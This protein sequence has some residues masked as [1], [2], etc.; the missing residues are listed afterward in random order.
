MKKVLAIGDAEAIKG[1]WAILNRSEE[2][3]DMPVVVLES[4]AP[5]LDFLRERCQVIYLSDILQLDM[6]CYDLIFLCSDYED[7]VKKILID[8]LGEKFVAEKVRDGQYAT[9]FLPGET[10]ME[11][12]REYLYHA[13]HVNNNH[14]NVSIGSFT[15][16][17]PYIRTWELGEQVNIGKFCSIAENVNILGGGEHRTDWATTY[18]FNAL[19]SA[20]DHIQGHPVS[21]GPVYIGN[22]VWLASGCTIMSGVTIGDGAVVA[23]NALVAKDVPAYAIV[24]GNPAKLIRYRFTEEIRQKLLEIKWWD[25]EE[26]DIYYAVPLLQS[27]N[28][29]ELFRYYE[30]NVLV[31]RT[32]K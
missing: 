30:D 4:S 6:S 9:R 10:A 26:K 5:N 2:S 24:G 16:G 29:E 18:P 7:R 19:I 11:Y 28:F 31:K 22:D 1:L 15:Y 8:M 12:L 14:P 13:N 20:F 21:K 27:S 3:F 32:K 25:W 23:A 17:V